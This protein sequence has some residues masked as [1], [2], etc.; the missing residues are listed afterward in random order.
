MILLKNYSFCSIF[1]IIVNDETANSIKRKKSKQ[2]IL[3]LEED[4]NKEFK[5]KEIK[6]RNEIEELSK[7]R[8]QWRKDHSKKYLVWWLL[9]YIPNSINRKWD[10]VRQKKL[11]VLLKQTQ[12]IY[13]DRKKSK[14]IYRFKN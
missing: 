8:K 6:I 9:K 3:E 11:G 12:K 1:S 14:N 4:F 2:T 13:E 5:D 10:G 7:K